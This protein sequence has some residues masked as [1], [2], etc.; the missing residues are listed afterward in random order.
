MIKF[1]SS[2]PGMK[3]VRGQGLSECY[4][5]WAQDDW[6]ASNVWRENDEMLDEMLKHDTGF[7]CCIDY[8]S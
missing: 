5:D 7:I 4:M 1:Q 2:A 8:S 3:K 6:L